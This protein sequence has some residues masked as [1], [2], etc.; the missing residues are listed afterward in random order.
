MGSTGARRRVQASATWAAETPS[1][2]ATAHTASATGRSFAD[3]DSG[4]A[5]VEVPV[6][7]PPPNGAHAVTLMPNASAIGS[8]SRSASRQ[9]RL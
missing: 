1:S 7:A 5:R 4:A 6:N 8:S 9:I 3:S 2:P